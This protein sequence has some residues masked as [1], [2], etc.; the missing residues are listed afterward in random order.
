MYQKTIL[1]NGIRVVTETIPYVRTVSLGFWFRTGSR[2]ETVENNG[3]SHLIEHLMF[4]GTST[5]SAREI[6]ELIDAAGGQLNAFTGKERTCYY[7]RILDEQLPMAAELLADMFLNSVFDPEEMEKEKNV[8]IEE[9]R[10]CED[11]PDELVHD[12]FA[13]AVLGDHPLGLS[14]LGTEA[15][16]RG[17]KREE[18]LEFITDYYVPGNLVVA[19]AGNVAHDQ[20]VDQVT[21]YFSALPSRPL[22]NSLAPVDEPGKAAFRY[23]DI[24]QVH[25]CIGGLGVPRH[26][27]DKFAVYVLDVILGGGMSSRLFQQLREERGLAYST[28][29]YHT[30]FQDAGVFGVY[31]GTGPENVPQVVRIIQDEFDRLM[32]EGVTP[33]ELHRGKEQLKGSLMLG[34][35]ST[36][37]RMSR[38]AKSELFYEAILTPDEVAARI[39][40]VT[41]ESV[42][43]VAQRLLSSPLTA[44]AIGPTE[45][46]LWQAG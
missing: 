38:I 36:A 22:P 2:N 30:C 34:L 32:Q 11:S 44:A 46:A 3:I 43:R 35:E 5:R 14:V 13:S 1:P 39:D 27:E 31:V 18:V 4:K 12:L 40:A 26:D 29:S 8:V 24:E 16:I 45:D 21:R 15:N 6:A 9:I 10:M 41:V 42:Q 33:E 7:A 28:Y 25:L 23:K 37:A 19:A 17:M 20:V